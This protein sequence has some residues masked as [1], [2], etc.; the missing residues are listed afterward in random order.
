[1]KLINN[2]LTYYLVKTK[3]LSKG[4]STEDMITCNTMDI[5]NRMKCDINSCLCTF[6]SNDAFD[7]LNIE[8]L[9]ERLIQ[10][11]LIYNE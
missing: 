5:Q 9:K 8:I 7:A 2:R 10:H 3:L 1:M 4:K 6:D 11:V